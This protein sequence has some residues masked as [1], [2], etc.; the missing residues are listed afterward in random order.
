MAFDNFELRWKFLKFNLGSHN[1][2]LNFTPFVDMG[3]VT[4]NYEFEQTSGAD[5]FAGE[6]KLHLSYGSGIQIGWNETTIVTIDY[7][8]PL[9]KQDGDTNGFYIKTSFLF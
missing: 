6:E 4:G 8:I 9:D 7:G 5:V 3:M 2:Y 1:F